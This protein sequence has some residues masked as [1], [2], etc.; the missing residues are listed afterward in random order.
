MTPCR[1]ALAFFSTSLLLAAALA[2]P[3]RAAEPDT[4][5]RL[6]L[7]ELE[8]AL[9]KKPAPYLVLEPAGPRLLVKSRGLVLASVPIREI[10]RLAFRPLFGGNEP[11]PL[12]APTVWTVTQGPGDTDRETIAPTTL[13]PYSEED[14]MVEPTPAPA[15]GATPTPK[16]GDKDKPSTY[17]VALDNGWQLFLVEERPRLGW[18]Q[19]FAAAVRDGWQRLK[20]EEPSHPP[21]IALVL[22]PDEAR[23]L[24][25]LFRSGTEI[26]VAPAP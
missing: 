10:H 14:E 11:P 26:L 16:P 22:E 9:A 4:A 2:A 6:R 12:V 7:A 18:F 20:G 23:G 3:A 19:R 13:K 17:R 15:P 25:H 1:P 24:H 5:L 8:S 21:L